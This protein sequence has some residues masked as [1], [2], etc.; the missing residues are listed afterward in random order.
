MISLLI[1]LKGGP[2][3][4]GILEG[5]STVPLWICEDSRALAAWRTVCGL[6]GALISEQRERDLGCGLPKARPWSSPWH[7]GD[8][9]L[10]LSGSRLA[11][12]E[13]SAT[14]PNL[15]PWYLIF[16]LDLSFREHL[17]PHL[18]QIPSWITLLSLIPLYSLY[19]DWFCFPLSNTQGFWAP[20]FNQWVSFIISE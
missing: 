13:M 12:G 5:K 7:P 17:T 3:S 20:S 9:P 14:E 10:L 19:G 15:W 2:W 18:S 8:L 4:G 16:A 11:L 1:V 6:W